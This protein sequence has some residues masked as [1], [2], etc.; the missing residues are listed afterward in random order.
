MSMCQKRNE[1]AIDV[2]VA[3]GVCIYMW[4]VASMSMCQK[5]NENTIDIKVGVGMLR[6]GEG[7]EGEVAL[8]IVQDAE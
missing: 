3:V 4:R 2:K 7:F 5:R 8:Y 6:Q 1:N